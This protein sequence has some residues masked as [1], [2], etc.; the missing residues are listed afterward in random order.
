MYRAEL[1]KPVVALNLQSRHFCTPSRLGILTISSGCRAMRQYFNAQKYYTK[2]YE[3]VDV[4]ARGKVELYSFRRVKSVPGQ[5]RRGMR[6]TVAT[7]TW[8]IM[9]TRESRT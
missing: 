2:T 4:S 6:L 9:G 8:L 3:V 7:G 1:A 5:Q